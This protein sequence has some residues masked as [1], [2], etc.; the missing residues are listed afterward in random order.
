[1]NIA[2]PR[3]P[4][5][6]PIG[7]AVPLPS[8]S[9]GVS[10]R[11]R[12]PIGPVQYIYLLPMLLLVG[13]FLLYPA[14]NTAWLSFTDSN[15][16]NNPTFIGLQNYTNLFTDPAFSTSFTNTLLW[17]VGVLVLQVT[18]GLIIAMVLSSVRGGDIMKILFYLPATISG[19]SV[20]VVWYFMF[21]P[22][23]GMINTT[24]RWLHL[25]GVAQ[26]WLTNVP[27]NT[28]ALI[29]AATW[30]GLGPNMLLFLVGLQNIPREP[31]EAGTLDGAGPVRLFWSI[32]LPL[33]RPMLTI[34]VGIALI[35]SFK[36][37]DLIWVMTQGGPYRSTETLA[38][39]M[40]RESFVSFQLGYGA[41]IAIV[42]SLIVMVVSIPYLRTM[43]ARDAEVY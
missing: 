35:N 36:V 14:L 5:I 8:A 41:A 10:R 23:E 29:V 21:D 13:A 2:S 42:L 22:A 33:L 1:M 6:E 40:Y 32:T 26:D 3:E 38:V 27:I 7:T 11:K 30:Q 20:A 28:W 34:V 25:G 24:L 9:G 18:L 37:F 43:F 19:A 39:T 31:L 4:V 12:P 15:G 16:L 17:V